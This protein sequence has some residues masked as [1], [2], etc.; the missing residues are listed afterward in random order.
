MAGGLSYRDTVRQPSR[1][2]ISRTDD[3]S[4]ETDDG[5]GARAQRQDTTKCNNT[6]RV[7]PGESDSSIQA[8]DTD[9]TSDVFL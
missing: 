9:Q 1:K 6:D 5:L 2:S 7:G 8:S 3:S 4:A